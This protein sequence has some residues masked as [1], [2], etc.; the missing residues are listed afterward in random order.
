MDKTEIIEKLRLYNT[1][2]IDDLEKLGNEIIKRSRKEVEDIIRIWVED[3]EGLME[4]ASELLN[5]LG[6]IAIIPLL[7]AGPDLIEIQRANLILMTGNAQIEV[8]K[9]IVTSIV[10]LLEDKEKIPYEIS[11]DNVEEEPPI[12]RVCDEAYLQLRRLLNTTESE[13]SY[14][15]NK[16]IYLHLDFNERDKEIADTKASGK[17]DRWFNESDEEE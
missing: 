17:W 8:R 13:K 3:E 12:R 11:L 1:G 9:K 6:D 7:E 4:D 2:E 15:I 10:P 5:E 14:L 16:S